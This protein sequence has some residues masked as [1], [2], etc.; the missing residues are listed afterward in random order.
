MSNQK[1]IPGTRVDEITF[2]DIWQILVARKW[3][4]LS[5]PII[6]LLLSALFLTQTTVEYECSAQVLVGQV[7][8]GHKVE[9]AAVL[10]Q[11]LAE[12]Y[13]VY[14][15]AAVKDLPRVSS[16]VQNK[17]AAGNI[18]QIK[19]VDTTAQGA[20]VYLERVVAEILAEHLTLY[21]RE[22]DFKQMRLKALSNRLKTVETFQQELDG[23]I[24]KMDRLDPAQATV[25]AVEK[26][27]FL[28]LASELEKESFDLQKDLSK[29]DS[30]PS[31]LLGMPNL[32]EKPYKPKQ[33][34]VILLAGI[35]GLAVGITAAF[36]VE[37]ILNARQ[38][39]K[40]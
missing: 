36:I 32:P 7:G 31:K 23:R 12:K 5:A 33:V 38:R 18:M 20:K 6:A 9:D 26:G 17:Q 37:F 14:D 15:K 34:L 10:V 27:G 29:V 1:H 39:S 25:L 13:R 19:A 2:F 16:V 11:K 3:V 30:Y 35:S 24:A 8:T 4:V 22:I 28:N 21:E 40:C